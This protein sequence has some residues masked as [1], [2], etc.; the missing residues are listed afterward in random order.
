M[1]DSKEDLGIP[2]IIYDET[3][4]DPLLDVSNLLFDHETDMDDVLYGTLYDL[5]QATILRST[6]P[7][8]SILEK[9]ATAYE[10]VTA[11]AYEPFAIPNCTNHGS[12]AATFE[13]ILPTGLMGKVLCRLELIQMLLKLNPSIDVGNAFELGVGYDCIPTDSAYIAN[14]TSGIPGMIRFLGR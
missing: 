1:K 14:T 12:A 10:R 3:E 13:V 6:L 4:S 11:T 7:A 9:V 2:D 8:A 5:P